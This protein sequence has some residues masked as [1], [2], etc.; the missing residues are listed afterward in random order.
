VGPNQSTSTPRNSAAP[1]TCWKTPAHRNLAVASGLCRWATRPCQW[2]PTSNTPSRT[3]RRQHIPLIPRIS[4]LPIHSSTARP[5][6]S[7]HKWHNSSPFMPHDLHLNLQDT[8]GNCLSMATSLVARLRLRRR[9]YLTVMSGRAT[10]TR[11]AGCDYHFRLSS[12]ITS[13][14]LHVYRAVRIVWPCQGV[15]DI[16][17]LDIDSSKPPI[18]TPK[19]VTITTSR[20]LGSRSVT[21]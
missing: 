6:I 4:I 14:R 17:P 9:R 19:P 8:A 15:A 13:V 2:A 18:R 3:R 20:S 5:G 16:K 10:M 1:G 7:V 11:T 12:G 21:K